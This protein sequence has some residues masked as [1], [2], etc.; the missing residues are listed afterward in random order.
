[1]IRTAGENDELKSQNVLLKSQLSKSFDIFVTLRGSKK[2]EKLRSDHPSIELKKAQVALA[3]V[4]SSEVLGSK[5]AWFKF[6]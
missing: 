5:K 2:L 1:M 3:E 4:R 6:W